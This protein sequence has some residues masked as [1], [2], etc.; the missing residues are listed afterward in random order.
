MFSDE[1]QCARVSVILQGFLHLFVLAKLA[2]NSIRVEMWEVKKDKTCKMLSNV[3][4]RLNN[5]GTVAK[6]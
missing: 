1:Y 6:S 2:A 3:A 5:F 4:S